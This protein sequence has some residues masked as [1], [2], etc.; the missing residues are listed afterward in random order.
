MNTA[1]VDVAVV[2]GGPAGL[3]AAV[4][5]R[6][7]GASVTVLER[8]QMLGGIARHADHT[9]YGLREFHRLLRGPAYAR[10]WA[11]RAE[12]AG[13]VAETGTTVTG[14]S[15]DDASTRILTLTSPQGIRELHARAVVLATGTRERPRSARLVPGSRPL[16]VLTTGALQQ[17]VA[18]GR[19]VPATFGVGRRAVIIGAEHVSFSAVL[20]LAHAGC[21]TVAMVTTEPRHQSYAALRAMTASRHRVP[22]LTRTAITEIRG[23]PRVESVEVCDL[24]TGTTRLLDCD[25][26]VFTGDWVPDHE[27]A[28]RGGLPIDPGTRAPRV[29]A[30]LRTDAPGVFAAGNLLHGA[31]TA[32]VCAASGAWTAKAVTQWLADADASTWATT[33]GVRIECAPPLRWV[34]PN[35]LVP[36]QHAVPHGHLLARSSAFSRRPGIVVSQGDRELWSGRL[37]RTVPTM[38]VH[39]PAGWLGQVEPG[40]PVRITLMPRVTGCNESRG[41][42]E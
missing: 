26:V 34:S 20:T 16:G 36:G 25:T 9:G 17:I 6:S 38:P 10:R 4:A 5:L 2:G 29:D 11:E 30:G 3:A 12:H 8:E 7:T 39:L 28:R 13:V 18:L 41:N 37:R 35:L 21:T 42:D 23:R 27:L 33:R 14:W 40:D 19:G 32:S 1:H 15:N 22:V 24:A 31:E